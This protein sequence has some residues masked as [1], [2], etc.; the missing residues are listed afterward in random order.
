MDSDELQPQLE[1]LHPESF[2]WALRC[3][4]G[5]HAEAEDVLQTTYLKILDG[6]ARYR[7][8]SSLKTWLFSVIRKTAAGG[9]RQRAL[10]ERLLGESQVQLPVP[11]APAP[12]DRFVAGAEQKER[13]ERALAGLARRQ[14]QVVE[15]ILSHELSLREAASV[16]GISIGSARTHYDRAK[17]RLASALGGGG[18]T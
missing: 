15:L 18:A 1:R 12:P 16:L 13:L 7:G 10:R 9:F 4:G 14:R 8:R 11:A 5:D 17:R 6:R 3:C 2:S